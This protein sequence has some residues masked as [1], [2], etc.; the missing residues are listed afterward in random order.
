[1]A[2]SSASSFSL[3][4][5]SNIFFDPTPLLVTTL[6]LELESN[7]ATRFKKLAGVT[8]KKHTFTP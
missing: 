6:A 2:M 4:I 1:M 8:Y 5:L 3:S 7:A